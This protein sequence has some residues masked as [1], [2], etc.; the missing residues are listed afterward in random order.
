VIIKLSRLDF[1][2]SQ[3]LYRINQQL[4]KIFSLDTFYELL[5][6]FFY[7]LSLETPACCDYPTININIPRFAFHYLAVRYISVCGHVHQHSHQ[8]VKCESSEALIAAKGRV[9]SC[10]AVSKFISLLLNNSS[11]PFSY[12]SVPAW[13]I[14]PSKLSRLTT[15]NPIYRAPLGIIS[16]CWSRPADRRRNR[17][18]WS[19]GTKV[20]REGKDRGNGGM[21]PMGDASTGLKAHY[22]AP[23]G[24]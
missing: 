1:T 22:T 16:R 4:I 6:S 24:P 3:I 14:K 23:K 8:L 7:E 12:A 10:S 11:W 15:I 19:K 20:A 9:F 2:R 13:M 17:Y 21:A 5:K 18:R